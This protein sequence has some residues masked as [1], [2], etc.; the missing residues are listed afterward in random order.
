MQTV[1]P[2]CTRTT[3]NSIEIT[4]FLLDLQS[5]AIKPPYDSSALTAALQC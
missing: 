1:P 4:L 3:H 2:A 5:V